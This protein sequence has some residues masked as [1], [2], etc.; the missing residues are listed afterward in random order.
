MSTNQASP[1]GPQIRHR[2]T[3]SPLSLAFRRLVRP[4]KMPSLPRKARVF[5]WT[6]CLTTEGQRA[7]QPSL[8]AGVCYLMKTAT[9][10]TRGRNDNHRRSKTP[11]PTPVRASLVTRRPEWNGGTP[12]NTGEE[13]VTQ[14]V[15]LL[16][17]M[18]TCPFCMFYLKHVYFQMCAIVDYTALQKS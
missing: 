8:R 4:T 10:R 17:K 14:R 2:N 11:C 18:Q 5:P 1:L 12:R 9:A 3:E 7:Q 16:H 13:E 6:S 15:H